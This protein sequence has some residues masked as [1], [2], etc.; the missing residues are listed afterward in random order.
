MASSGAYSRIIACLPD[1]RRVSPAECVIEPNMT[2]YVVLKYLKMD[3]RWLIV[4]TNRTIPTDVQAYTPRLLQAAFS[5]VSEYF[6]IRKINQLHGADYK[7]A[8]V[9]EA[10]IFSATHLLQ[11]YLHFT[12]FFFHFCLPRTLI[13]SLETALMMFIAPAW[14]DAFHTRSG[15]VPDRGGPSLHTCVPR[16]FRC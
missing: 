4:C 14:M 5:G 12:N 6:W 10:Y 15:T 8:M 2:S 16:L 9:R 13:N 1:F 3:S 11:T 7:Q